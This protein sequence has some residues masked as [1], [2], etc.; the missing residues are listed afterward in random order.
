M[1]LPAWRMNQTGVA[2][3]DCRL[4]ALRKRLAASLSSSP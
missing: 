2:S 4:Q 1:Y 3:T